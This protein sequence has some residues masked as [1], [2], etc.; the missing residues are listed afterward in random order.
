MEKLSFKEIESNL[1][2]LKGWRESDNIL[3]TS[4]KLDTFMQ[5]ISFVNIV[6]DKSEKIDHHPKIII[7]YNTVIFEL[8][9]HSV[10]GLTALDIELAKF[11]HETF[12]ELFS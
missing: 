11:I 4:Y 5:S 10:N 12:Y 7:D 3:I 9:T 2:V 1:L 6:C 8:T